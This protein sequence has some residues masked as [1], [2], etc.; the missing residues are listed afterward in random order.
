MQNLTF[1][2]K[3]NLHAMAEFL[4]SWMIT[5]KLVSYQVFNWC[6]YYSYYH[7][8]LF[9]FSQSK[10]QT[11]RNITCPADGEHGAHIK[12]RIAGT[13][14]SLTCAR[15]RHRSQ[16]EMKKCKKEKLLNLVPSFDSFIAE[17]TLALHFPEANAKTRVVL[18]IYRRQKERT[19]YVTLSQFCA[20]ITAN[21]YNCASLTGSIG[22]NALP[23]T[24]YKNYYPLVLFKATRIHFFSYLY[25]VSQLASTAITLS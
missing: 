23:I 14:Y 25:T 12:C 24:Y 13:L 10:V 21:M 2:F 3:Q 5:K 11:H 19:R 18:L 9:C 4:T 16:Y 17:V 22:V 15:L 20:Q 1:H 7:C 6:N 8:S